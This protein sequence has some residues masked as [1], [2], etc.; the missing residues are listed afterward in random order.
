MK[1]VLS[2]IAL[3]LASASALADGMPTGQPEGFN[4]QSMVLLV[5]FVAIFYFL[6]IR[7]QMKRNKEHRNLV[8][9]LNKGDEVVTNG[10]VIGKISK[11]GEQIIEL[12]LSKGVIVKVQKQ[13]VANLLPKGSMSAE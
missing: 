11:V 3:G 4:W 5:A 7:P 13:A 2:F 6:M 8:S 10:G 1:R 12:E 9:S